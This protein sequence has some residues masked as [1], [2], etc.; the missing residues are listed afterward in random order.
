[1]KRLGV[2]VL[3]MLLSLLVTAALTGCAADE[4]TSEPLPAVGTDWEVVSYNDQ[5]VLLE[6]FLGTTLTLR[7]NADGTAT[8]SGG[9]NTFTGPYTLEGDN[10]SIGPLA[11]TR[12]LCAEPAQTM[13]QEATY[14]AAL[15]A[16]QKVVLKSYGMEF[17]DP[18]Q[19]TLILFEQATITE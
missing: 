1:M 3:I 14:L 12:M 6:P 4:P 9:C 18:Q 16:A 15:Q 11:T 7:L 13:D 5:D 19:A 8:G 17:T 2:Y 10:I